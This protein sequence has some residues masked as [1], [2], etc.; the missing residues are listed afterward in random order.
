MEA[1]CKVLYEHYS[2]HD[3]KFSALSGSANQ[4]QLDYVPDSQ[5]M[6]IRGSKGHGQ[7]ITLDEDRFAVFCSSAF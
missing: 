3:G 2:G 4:P 1:T 6:D 7:A 5:I